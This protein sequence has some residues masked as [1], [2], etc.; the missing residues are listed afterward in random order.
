MTKWS[1]TAGIWAGIW[2]SAGS[3]ANAQGVWTKLTP[4]PERT[5]G[6]GI[7]KVG[8]RIV[9]AYGHSPSTGGDNTIARLYDIN[10]DT[11]TLAAPAPGPRRSEIAYGDPSHGGFIYVAGGRSGPVLKDLD[12]YDP[13]SNTWTVLTPMPTA[14][15]AAGITSVANAL[16]VIGG[17]TTGGGPCSGGALKTVERYDIDTDTWS[18]VASLPLAASDLGVVSHGGKIY[19][20][21]GCTIGGSSATKKVFVYNPVTDTWAM[22][23]DMPTQ[24]ASVVAAS[25]GN[26]IYVIG[27][28]NGGP[29]LATNEVYNVVKDTWATDT[30][31]I[32]GRGESNSVSHGGRIYVV[33][34]SL[35]GF[36]ASTDDVEVFKP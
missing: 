34:G 28:F 16:Y 17:R 25:V 30:P 8:N 10:T 7:G 35:P 14:R 15:A 22:G 11:W 20:F 21:G 4:L 24:R 18:A 29:P 36:G 5:E 1:I 13:A 19:A 9:V 32:V 26:R 31:I 12:R 2:L 27:G 33:G 3:M 23:A 6:L